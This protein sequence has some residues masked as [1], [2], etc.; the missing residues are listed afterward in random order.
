DQ[1]VRYTYSLDNGKTFL[2]LGAPAQMRF[3]WWKGARP[4]L[5]SYNVTA[6]QPGHGMVDVDWVRVRMHA[7][8]LPAADRN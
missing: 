4:G 8:T 2:P 3:S 1:S 7:S 6:D 5:F